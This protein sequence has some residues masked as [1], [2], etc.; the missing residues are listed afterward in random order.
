MNIEKSFGG[1]T[2]S[3][4][5]QWLS[6]RI[7]YYQLGDNPNDPHLKSLAQDVLKKHHLTDEERAGLFRMEGVKDVWLIAR[8]SKGS[9]R[10]TVKIDYSDGQEA[11]WI[12]KPTPDK[13]FSLN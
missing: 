2:L 9:E 5:E 1:I 7:L 12:Y 6:S 3:Q 13:Q 8:P 10:L 4:V 11:S